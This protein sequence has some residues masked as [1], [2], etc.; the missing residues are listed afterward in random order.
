MSPPILNITPEELKIRVGSTS[1]YEGGELLDV[2][3]IMIHPNWGS[4][5]N[6]MYMDYDFAL[7][8]LARP[9]RYSKLSRPINLP[10]PN[11]DPEEGLPV[12]ISGW[13]ETLDQ[14]VDRDI[15]RAI[16]IPII[17]RKLCNER[18]KAVIGD[19]LGNFENVITDRM[20]CAAADAPGKFLTL[21]N[22]R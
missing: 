18:W 10:D 21:S 14:T 12:F 5:L 4:K 20:V 9:L 15:L 11:E 22:K 19:E 2:H 8:E 6:E 16:E 7:V 3:A 1:Y 13:G 17:D